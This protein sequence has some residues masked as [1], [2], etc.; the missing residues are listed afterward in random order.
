MPKKKTATRRSYN[1]SMDNMSNK[2]VPRK[3]APRKS[4]TYIYRYFGMSVNAD[5]QVHGFG[6]FLKGKWVEI[7][8]KV[9]NNLK[10]GIDGAGKGEDVGWK[11]KLVKNRM[12][13]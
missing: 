13:V 7:P 3:R 2:L 9:Y 11:V 5:R 1:K 12:E 8:K 4:Y 10:K 6:S